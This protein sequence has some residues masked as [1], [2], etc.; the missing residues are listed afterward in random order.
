MRNVTIMDF[1][2]EAFTV[3]I[4]TIWVAYSGTL[5]LGSCTSRHT[6]MTQNY[7]DFFSNARVF[8]INLDNI[9]IVLFEYLMV[10]N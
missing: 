4:F 10:L 9:D 7:N 6:S 8:K 1:T 5:Q 3:R 2:G